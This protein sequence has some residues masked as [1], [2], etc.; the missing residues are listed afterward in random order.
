MQQI[1]R[2]VHRPHAAS[3]QQAFELIATG[4]H[5]RQLPDT[6]L[7]GGRCGLAHRILGKGE[8]RQV[9]GLLGHFQQIIG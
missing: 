3:A 7:R 6:G 5:L 9:R 1:P 2:P 8:V 4:K